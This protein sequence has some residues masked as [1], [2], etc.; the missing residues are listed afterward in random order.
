MTKAVPERFRAETLPP[1][2]S[3]GRVKTPSR[4]LTHAALAL[5]AAGLVFFAALALVLGKEAAWDFQNYHWY[6]P[7]ALLNGRRFFDIAVA[8][9]ATYYSPLLDLPLWW[10]ANAGPGWWGGVWLGLHAG[11]AAILIGAI[12]WQVLP[13][14]D[15]RTRLAVA[16]LLGFF[17]ALGGGTLSQI[18]STSN[19]ILVGLPVLASWL[20]LLL[21]ADCRRWWLLMLSGVL[22]GFAVGAK[23]TTGI[24]AIGSVCA[25]LALP[26]GA[27]GKARAVLL[28]GVGG[29][30]GAA[31]TGGF[32]WYTLWRETGNPLFPFANTIFKS[33]LIKLAD[34]S[35]PTFRPRDWFTRIFF[36]F[37][38]TAN[39][40][41][42]AEW[43]FRDLRILVAYVLA[44]VLL[45]LALTRNTS[46]DPL[47]HRTRGRMLLLAI[48]GA[49]V[50]WALLF[51]IYRYAL[52]LEMLAPV[53]IAILIGWVRA[54]RDARIVTVVLL[55]VVTQALV[56]VSVDRVSFAGR[57]VEV[58]MQPI[59]TDAMVLG[60]GKYP[61]AYVIPSAPPSVP[62]LRIDGWLVGPKDGTGLTAMME[63][64]VAAHRG[65]LYVIFATW[66]RNQRDQALAAYGLAADD[67]ACST[68]TSNIG[69]PLAFCRVVR[70]GST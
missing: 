30:I 36:P 29:A 20:V 3:A 64:R 21:A 2:R 69:R 28:F 27:R 1:V 16:S 57:Y 70:R 52:P 13:L 60:T 39:S 66:E 44:F 47:A 6:A 48:A 54:P 24:Y 56:T 43:D 58:D 19:D 59:E 7:Y 42:V 55:A 35:D 11:I 14:H 17:G 51:G 40:R 12:A 46:P 34:Y 23:L 9:H 10:I 45:V 38:F 62:W 63:R 50:P 5:S 41:R 67:A 26:G 33:E 65:P 68:V 61:Y 22:C 53:A 18:G 15:A 4:V 8:H 49:Y 31:V 25:L 32:W 37:V